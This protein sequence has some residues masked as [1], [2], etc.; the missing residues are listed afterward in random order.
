MAR[1]RLDMAYVGT[2]FAGWQLQ[3]RPGAEARRTVQGETEKAL[4]AVLGAPV[5]LHGAGR[6]DSGVHADCQTAHFDAPDKYAAINWPAALQ[7]H[8][9]PDIAIL[10][11]REAAPDFHARFSAKGKVY[12]YALWTSEAPLPPKLR[13]FCWDAGPLDTAPMREAAHLLSGE[14]DFA[15]FQ[16]S[17]SKVKDTVRRIRSIRDFSLA[18]PG[19]ASARP[20]SPLVAWE[21]AGNGFLKQMVRNL[22]GFMAA[23]GRH[24]LA[25]D[26]AVA[27]FTAKRRGALPFPTAPACGLTLRRVEY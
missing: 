20:D 2:A 12:V 5:R 15:S 11:A 1:I 25:P 17:G 18:L 16:N 26:D 9:P 8:L 3:S 21:F 14:H 10:A 23:C 6:T 7:R 22:M 24:K 13:P 19:E 27:L 4:A